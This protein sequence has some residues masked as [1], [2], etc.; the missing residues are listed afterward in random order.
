MQICGINSFSDEEEGQKTKPTVESQTFQKM[1]IGIG[2]KVASD[3]IINT[4]KNHLIHTKL[5][6]PPGSSSLQL[7]FTLKYFIFHETWFPRY[8]H[9]RNQ[10]WYFK[11]G[12]CWPAF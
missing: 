6:G 9:W 10:L 1:F 2:C 11:S 3:F 12:N 5:R 7:V 8:Q 4:S